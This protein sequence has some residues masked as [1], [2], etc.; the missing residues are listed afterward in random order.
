MCNRWGMDHADWVTIQLSEPL[1]DGTIRYLGTACDGR[2]LT[3]LEQPGGD[4][5]PREVEPLS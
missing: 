3:L 5:E 1:P 4:L 2:T